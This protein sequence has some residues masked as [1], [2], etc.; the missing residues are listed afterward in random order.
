[1]DFLVHRSLQVCAALSVLT[2]AGIVLVLARESFAFF[3]EVSPI[4]F[5]F[6]LHWTPLL[7]PRS[8]GVLPLVG[9]TLMIVV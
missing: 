6:G 4:E 5:L 7:E 2:T 8:F 3:R 1:M 9:G